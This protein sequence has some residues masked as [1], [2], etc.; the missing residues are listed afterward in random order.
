MLIAA[1]AMEGL[2]YYLVNFIPSSIPG[3]IYRI[4]NSIIILFKLVQQPTLIRSKSKDDDKRIKEEQ[5]RCESDLKRVYIYA[6]RAI[7]TQDQTNLNRYA[8][9]KGRRKNFISNI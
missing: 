4:K 7:Q 8:L 5:I 9:V 1:G 2:I 3:K 6:S